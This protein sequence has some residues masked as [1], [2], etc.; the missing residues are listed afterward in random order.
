MSDAP[1]DKE[2]KKLKAFLTEILLN[3]RWKDGL[4]DYQWYP[5]YK[6]HLTYAGYLHTRGYI[7]YAPF[8]S[9]GMYRIAVR[10]RKW[11]EKQQKGEL[12]EQ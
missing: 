1:I 12:N 3:D 10:G 4:E 5:N 2:V 11:L 9:G 6:K 8:K 7:K